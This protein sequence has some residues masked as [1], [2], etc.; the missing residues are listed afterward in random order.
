MREVNIKNTIFLDETWINENTRKDTGWTDGTF[1]GTL[2]GP[3]GKGK[4]LIICH[5]GRYDEYTKSQRDRPLAV[6]TV[7][8]RADL[9][10]R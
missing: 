9:M 4:Q 1:Q 10:G 2:G 7:I 3:L 6:L 5:G 8:S